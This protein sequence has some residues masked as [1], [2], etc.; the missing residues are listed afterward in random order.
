MRC[1]VTGGAGFIGS[2]WT[3]HLLGHGHAVI[4]IDNLITG[5]LQNLAH[6]QGHPGFQFIHQDVTLDISLDGPVDFV[7]HFA[8]P[9]SPADFKRFP[10]QILKAGAMGTHKTLGLA[11]AKG[12]RFLLAS[13]S[14]VYGDPQVHPQPESYWGNVNPLGERGVYDEAKRYAEALVMAYHRMHGLDTRIAR[15]FN[16]YGPRMRMDDGRLVPSFLACVQEGKP[17]TLHGDGQQTRSFAYISDLVAGLQ[18]L[19]ESDFHEPVN[20]GS[21]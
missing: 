6:L 5:S 4:V 19:S 16:T 12:A 17:L 1:V 10:I 7:Y 18:K 9:A 11:L 20:L 8:S 14:E 15:F 2:H 13:T 21:E 3:D